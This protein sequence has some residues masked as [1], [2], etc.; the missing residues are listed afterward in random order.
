MKFKGIAIV[1]LGNFYYLYTSGITQPFA[2]KI[3]TRPQ[4]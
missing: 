3:F 1:C 2:E 4:I